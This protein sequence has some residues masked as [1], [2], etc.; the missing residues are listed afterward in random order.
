MP[1]GPVVSPDHKVTPP[2]RGE[3][4]TSMEAL[5]HHFKLYTEASM[6]CRGILWRGGS[7]QGRVQASYLVADGSK[8]CPIAA[9]SAAPSYVHLQAIDY[10]SR[11]PHAGRRF[12]AV[13]GSLEH[14]VRG[15]WIGELIN[16][17]AVAQKAVDAYNAQDLDRLCL[18]F[19]EDCVVSGLNGPAHRDAAPRRQRRAMPRPSAQFPHKHKPRTEEP[20]RGRA[21]RWWITNG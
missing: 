17:C 11:G 7:A 8:Q 21:I 6:S 19:R 20:H 14:C 10:M 3:M 9:R 5:I 2:K 16:I 18:L 4:K 13:L 1:S 12:P 15:A